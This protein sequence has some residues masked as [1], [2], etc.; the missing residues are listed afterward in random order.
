MA[1][2]DGK[3]IKGSIG[4]VSFRKIDKNTTTVQSNPGKGTMKQTEGTKKSAS[5]FG[6]LVSPFAKH[7]RFHFKNLVNDFADRKMVNRMNSSVSIIMNQHLEPD[8]KIIFNADSFN[9]LNGFEFNLNSLLIDSL[10]LMPKV[11]YENGSLHL[12]FPSFKIAKNLKFPENTNKVI[13]QIQPVFFKLSKGLAFI[14][15]TEYIHLEKTQALAEEITFNYDFPAGSVCLVGLSLLFSSNQIAVNDKE[16]NP[17]GICAAV[18]REGI[19]DDL[20]AEGWYN[21]G[22]SIDV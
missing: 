9:R 2:Y 7:I 18:Y 12:T 8:G 16:F 19:A 20:V 21:I 4:N 15:P 10:L 17:A 6:N 5:L 22:F 14:A 1:L 13:I 11:I 3:N